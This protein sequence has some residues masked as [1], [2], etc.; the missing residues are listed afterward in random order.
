MNPMNESIYQPEARTVTG[1]EISGWQSDNKYIL[2]GYRAANAD[3]PK[4][5]R[6]LTF[7]HNESCNVYTHLIGALLLPLVA[8]TLLRY[9]AEPKFLN[10]STMDYAAFGIYFWCSE[11]CL[12]LSALYHL[13]QPYSY[14]VEQ[15]WHG[16]DLLGIVLM[17]VGTLFSGIYYVFFC[18]ASW[19]QL[20]WAMVRL[21]ER[22]GN[23]VKFHDILIW[24]SGLSYGYCYWYSN[25]KSVA[26]DTA[27]A[28]Y[29]SERLHYFWRFI[30]YTP[31]AWSSTIR[32]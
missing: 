29:K 26:Q 25:L 3:Y 19:Q 15:F 17:T 9:L 28:E 24:D 18:E 1:L 8:V 10:V 23:Q 22:Y 6:S 30:V 32:T 14:Q 12:I 7:L 16:M 11:V 27:L 2:S 4:I 5:L 21:F 20:H 31:A 13:M